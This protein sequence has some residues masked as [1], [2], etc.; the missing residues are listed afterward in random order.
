M[1]AEGHTEE[2]PDCRQ[3]YMVYASLADALAAGWPDAEQGEWQRGPNRD[4]E[5]GWIAL[6]YTPSD[7]E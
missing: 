5:P 6:D 2:R 3:R 4:P 7:D 1:N